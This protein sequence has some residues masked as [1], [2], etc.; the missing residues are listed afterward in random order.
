MSDFLLLCRC[1][2]KLLKPCIKPGVTT[3]NFSTVILYL[4]WHVFEQSKWFAFC[5][6]F[7][8]SVTC[9]IRQSDFDA[10]F[11]PS[12][13]EKSCFRWKRF[14]DKDIF[15]I[16]CLKYEIRIILA[17]QNT[18]FKKLQLLI[19]KTLN[20]TAWKVSVFGIFLVRIFPLSD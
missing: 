20:T 18:F 7:R 12:S 6:V 17:R 10:I 5:H 15:Q 14:S 11:I 3:D 9:K 8:M 16:I 1:D 4:K 2:N 19:F 13:P